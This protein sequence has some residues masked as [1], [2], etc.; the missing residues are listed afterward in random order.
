M[1]CILV[2]TSSMF[3]LLLYSPLRSRLTYGLRVRSLR[4]V[5][6]TSRDG[7][8]FWRLPEVV[9]RGNNIKYLRIPEDIIGMVPEEDLSAKGGGF[10]G[11][12]A[13]AE[14]GRAEARAG[15]K[16]DG[17]GK[18]KG[19]GRGKGGGKEADALR[20][21]DTA[22]PARAFLRTTRRADSW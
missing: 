17:D 19:G 18:G 21:V 13:A 5:I 4:G 11:V 14:G 3:H 20:G 16:G 22:E 15:G 7:D 10:G 9:I 8:R 1:E 12:A 6:C 2:L